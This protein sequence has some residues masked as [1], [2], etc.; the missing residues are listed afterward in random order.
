M[1]DPKVLSLF[2]FSETK[3][4]S[5]LG[6]DVV[7][8]AKNLNHQH[9][10][11]LPLTMDSHPSFPPRPQPMLL[12]ASTAALASRSRSTTELRPSRAAK[13]SGVP[14]REPR[15]E[16]KPQAEPNE[17]KGRKISE[18]IW[19]PQESKFWKLWP[20]DLLPGLNEHCGFE[21]S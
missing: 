13:C 18:K 21:I 1:L 7:V 11:P 2:F 8:I 16:A 3:S 17:T 20:L 4:K 10:H 12:F 15:P 6:K 5:S 19:A 9:L 14:P